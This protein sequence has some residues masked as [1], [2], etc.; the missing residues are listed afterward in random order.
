MKGIDFMKAEFFKAL[1]HPT[2]VR[3]INL[4]FYDERCVCEL[5]NELDLEQPNVSQ[6]LAIL[7]KQDIVDTTKK[8]LQVFYRIADPHI[9]TLMKLVEEIISDK[10]I[11]NTSLTQKSNKT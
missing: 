1:A 9:I 10:L 6:H 2:R 7:R 3:I 11:I 5:M 4:L 8:G